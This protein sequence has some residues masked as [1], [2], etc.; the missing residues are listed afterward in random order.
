MASFPAKLLCLFSGYVCERKDLLANGC[1]DVSVPSTKQHCCDGCLANGC[2][3]AYEYCV[4]CCLQPSKVWTPSLV[5]CA[6]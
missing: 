4:S 5:F 1:C 2:C 3:E 6:F